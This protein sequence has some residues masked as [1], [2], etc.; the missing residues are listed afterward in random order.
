MHRLIG[1]RS[2]WL[3]TPLLL[4]VLSSCI[5]TR[6]NTSC[7]AGQPPD[8]GLT[9]S[10]G[11]A[12]VGFG[13]VDAVRATDGTQLWK[14]NVNGDTTF[15]TLANGVLYVGS[16]ATLTALRSSDGKQLWQFKGTGYYARFNSGDPPIVSDGIVYVASTT[17]ISALQASDGKLLWHY[18]LTEKYS[19]RFVLN[20][21]TLYLDGS[22]TLT[23]LRASDGH[24]LWSVQQPSRGFVVSTSS[25]QVY[26]YEDTAVIALRVS[27][28]HQI[29]SFPLTAKSGFVYPMSTPPIISVAD[30]IYVG[31]QGTFYALR[32]RDGKPLWS[33]S[34]R[35]SSQPIVAKNMFYLLSSTSRIVALNASTGASIWQS[36]DSYI[37]VIVDSNRGALYAYRDD[38]KTQQSALQALK[39]SDGT[40]LWTAPNVSGIL[41]QMSTNEIYLASSSG[42]CNQP[43][44][45][46]V[47]AIQTSNG[48]NLWHIHLEP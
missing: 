23:A 36:S 8:T 20:Q 38:A 46:D 18:A 41:R 12:Y 5:G 25:N 7:S 48:H 26:L 34:A 29:W 19:P 27:D 2:S 45:S 44:T 3:L 28:G 16:G 6:V 37:D 11:V 22:T 10:N 39:L 31:S 30:I 24:L 17:Q 43:N 35:S 40:V 47:Y 4:I 14:T 21:Q 1:S 33:V 42:G 32:E 13:S 9:V 15:S